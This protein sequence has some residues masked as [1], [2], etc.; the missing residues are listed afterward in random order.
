MSAKTESRILL[1]KAPGE[2][3]VHSLSDFKR[4][5][6]AEHPCIRE[7][8]VTA[9][10]F[11]PRAEGHSRNRPSGS[12]GF[13]FLHCI[14][15]SGWVKSEDQDLIV[16]P[17]LGVFLEPGK[18]HEFGS[19]ASDPWSCYYI[20]YEGTMA[21]SYTRLI[22]D[23]RESG[24]CRI[25]GKGEYL[26]SFNRILATLEQGWNPQ[27]A[28]MA[29]AH[30]HKLLSHIYFSKQNG[31]KGT[32]PSSPESRIQAIADM[33]KENPHNNISVMELA[34]AAHLST[35]RFRELFRKLNG[36]SPKQFSLHAQIARAKELLL[37]D[38]LCI[39]EVALRAG[40]SNS[41]YFARIFSTKVGI[42]P[43][44]YRE[45]QPPSEFIH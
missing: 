1:R 25:K 19:S 40:F 20:H 33:I 22:L 2:R 32:R 34:R 27:N 29:S 23:E 17:H 43:S 18:A 45:K 31:A 11:Y 14:D 5:Q 37:S 26:K 30:L 38:S 42:T 15:G 13:V 10:G 41:H 6:L 36:M 4:R 16:T 3:R 24:T 44:E 9:A 35:S 39:H 7:L 8:M 21:A 12:S 28:L